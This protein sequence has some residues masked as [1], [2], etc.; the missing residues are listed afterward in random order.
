MDTEFDVVVIGGI[1]CD[2]TGKSFE[3]IVSATSNPGTVKITSGGVAGNI[4][5]NLSLL[6]V[7][8]A[9]LSSIGKDEFGKSLISN[10]RNKGINTEH[11]LTSHENA[12][13]IYLAILNEVGELN[14]GLSDM[15]IIREINVDY[16]KKKSHILKSCKYIICDTNL[17]RE[18]ILFLIEFANQNRIPICVEPVSVSKSKKLIGILDG[19]DIIT[20]NKNE[21]FSLAELSHDNG[22]IKHTAS[23]LLEKGVKNIILTLGSEGLMLIN[24]EGIKKFSSFKADIKNVTGAGDSLTAGLIYGLLKHEN[25][26]KACKYGLAAAALTISSES[27]VS[28][29]L[30]IETISNMISYS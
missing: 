17:D 27:T 4:A 21:L 3:G 10:L 14:L 23:S 30:S 12:T 1:N 25:P 15:I 2:I 24:K 28:N 16:L 11:I 29:R 18:S 22:D 19:I 13:G 8:T 7:K 6:G 5:Q 9:L 20:P 26:E